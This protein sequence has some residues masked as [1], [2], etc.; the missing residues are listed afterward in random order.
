MQQPLSPSR[1]SFSFR[2]PFEDDSLRYF[3]DQQ[4]HE[5]VA[6]IARQRRTEL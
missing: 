5:V 4:A 3:K 6:T 1:L 2:S